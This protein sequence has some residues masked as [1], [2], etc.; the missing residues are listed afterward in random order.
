MT[1]IREFR[2]AALS[3]GSNKLSFVVEAKVEEKWEGL[4]IPVYRDEATLRTLPTVK[5]IIATIR[6][7]YQASSAL[8]TSLNNG[9]PFTLK[10]ESGG[11]TIN[12]NQSRVMGWKVYGETDGD[13]ME[14][15]EITAEKE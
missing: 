4:E 11:D 15:V 7:E 12:F 5:R 10:F 2:N 3:L 9:T 13:L 14:E 6:R 1:G 8:H